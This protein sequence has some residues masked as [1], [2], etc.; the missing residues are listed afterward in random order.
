[1]QKPAS[2]KYHTFIPQTQLIFLQGLTNSITA[3]DSLC[4]ISAEESSITTDFSPRSLFS[5]V[6]IVLPKLD[7]SNSFNLTTDGDVKYFPQPPYLFESSQNVNW[8]SRN[9]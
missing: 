1:M 6:S 4:G 3:D 9:T 2:R 7:T 8:T 5:P